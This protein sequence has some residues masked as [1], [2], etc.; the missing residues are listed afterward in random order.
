MLSRRARRMAGISLVELMVGIAVGLVVVW[1]MSAVYVNSAQGSQTTTSANQ[2]NQDMRAVMDIMVNDIRRS[3]Y[4]GA[5]VSGAANPFTA[6]ATL[7]KISSLGTL[8]DCIVYSYDATFASAS[9]GV[10]AGVDF[11]GFRLNDAGV[12]QTLD[13]SGSS[14]LASTATSCANIV[15]QDLTDARSVNVTQLSFDTVGSKCIAF[16]PA[17]Y[18]PANSATFTT[19]TTAA[20]NGAACSPSASNAPVSYPDTTTNAFVETR[21][22]NITLKARSRTDT[23]LPEVTLTAAV[24]LRNNRVITP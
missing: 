14:T 16:V 4:W 11:F 9:P 3:G 8:R 21:Q 2:L 23:T 5:P 12:L 6:A 10:T 22:V 7:P 19:W 18:L 20:G 15:W 1:G 17:S 24:L 13:Q